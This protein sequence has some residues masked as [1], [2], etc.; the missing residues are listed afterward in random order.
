MKKLLMAM[1]PALLLACGGGDEPAAATEDSAGPGSSDDLHALFQAV[2]DAVLEVEAVEYTFSV[3]GVNVR[4]TTVEHST[5]GRAVLQRGTSIDDANIYMEFTRMNPDGSAGPVEYTVSNPEYAAYLNPAGGNY[6]YG[7]LEDGGAQIVHT[8]GFPQG[9]VLREFLFPVEPYGAELNAPGYMELEQEELSGILCRVIA[10]DMS[11]YE[12][13]WWIDPETMLPV[14]NRIAFW[15]PDGTGMEYR[16]VLSDINTGVVPSPETF[17]LECPP[18]IEPLQVRGSIPVGSPAPSWTL[19]TPEG[20]MVSLED[21]RGRVVVIDFW[22]TWCMPCRQVMPV[23]QEL[24]ETWGDELAVIGINTWEQAP[25]PAGFIRDLGMTYPVLLGGDQVAAEYL[26]EGIP[27]FYVIDRDGRIAFHAVGADPA[28]EEAL[29]EI[30]GTIL[31][32]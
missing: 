32:E 16:I 29:R 30:V 19:E 12:S 5:T 10:V 25:D 4:E 1:L 22:A 23:L 26:V 18:G 2:T 31:A 6:I 13:V 21:L 27:T 14:A 9:A 28:N 11:P 24:H 17:Q 15:N 3:E 7:L 20:G 8:N